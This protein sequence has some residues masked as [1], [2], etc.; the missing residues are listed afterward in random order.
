MRLKIGIAFILFCICSVSFGQDYKNNTKS[1]KE[2]DIKIEEG[3]YSADN[4]VSADRLI[5]A[6]SENT[7]L[8]QDYTSSCMDEEWADIKKQILNNKKR[9]T[10]NNEVFT[11]KIID[12]VFVT[13]QNFDKKSQLSGW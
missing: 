1:L 7:D 3:Q 11:S 10:K 8:S 13:T 6:S 4:S 12:T 2:V 9:V 5:I